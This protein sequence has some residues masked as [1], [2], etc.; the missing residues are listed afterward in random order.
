PP[1]PRQFNP[2]VPRDLETV[3]LKAIA[4]DPAHRYQTAG[5]L[6][7]DLQRFLDGRPITARPVGRIERAV[8]WVRRNPVVTAM[9]VAVVLALAVGTTVSYLKYLDAEEQQKE[10]E[11]Q[12]VIAQ[13]KGREA[14][15]QA[16]KA[17]KEA[18]KAE[19][20]TDYLVSIFALADAKG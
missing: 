2:D 16:D 11:K 19:R 9:A 15:Q 8:K 12:K 10:A 6:A 3:V 14:Q 4:R 13:G 20:A 18:A 1:R 17:K 5:A 7:D